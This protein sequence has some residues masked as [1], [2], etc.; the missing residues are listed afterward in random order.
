MARKTTPDIIGDILSPSSAKKSVKAI[1]DKQKAHKEEIQNSFFANAD[2][3]EYRM[4]ADNSFFYQQLDNIKND[5]FGLKALLSDSREEEIGHLEKLILF[6]KNY[7]LILEAN[8]LNYWIINARNSNG[9]DRLTPVLTMYFIYKSVK[10]LELDI[11]NLAE[12][13]SLSED[14]KIVETGQNLGSALVKTIRR[15]K[16]WKGVIDKKYSLSKEEI[17]NTMEFCMQLD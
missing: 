6:E 12:T 11:G 14:Q 1:T 4:P 2:D 15:L 13:L 3:A 7:Q 5:G 8:R 17:H 9:N 16:I 10:N